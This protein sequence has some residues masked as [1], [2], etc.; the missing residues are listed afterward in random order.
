MMPVT[1]ISR[2]PE[3]VKGVITLRG[4][5]IPVLDLRLKFGMGE[6]SYTDR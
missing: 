6:S 4:K 3:F 2:T 1:L 5:V